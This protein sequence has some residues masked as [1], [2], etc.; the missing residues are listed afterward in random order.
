MICLFILIYVSI[1]F[2]L[3]DSLCFNGNLTL[4]CR[5]KILDQSWNTY[6]DID[7]CDIFHSSTFL[8]DLLNYVAANIHFASY[9]FVDL[10]K[11]IYARSNT[12]I[13]Q[14]IACSKLSR[15]VNEI[16][17]NYRTY[18]FI[19]HLI[20]LELIFVLIKNFALN[21]NR[22]QLTKFFIFRQKLDYFFFDVV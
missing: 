18:S 11:G 2:F 22:I 13:H 20:D 17:L 3:H 6:F 9:Y 1:A 16:S 8:N 21:Q 15:Y 14:L 19:P 5:K 10:R 4:S 12:H 7:V